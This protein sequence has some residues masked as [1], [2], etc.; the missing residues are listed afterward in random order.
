MIEKYPYFM[1]KD[2]DSN[3]Y[4]VTKVYDTPF[5][6]LYN[7]LYKVYQDFH[8]NK[9]IYIWKEQTAPYEYNIHFHTHHPL[10][11]KIT[12]YK[13]NIPINKISVPLE[14]YEE[15]NSSKIDLYDSNVV[16][17]VDENGKTIISPIQNWD[18]TY[19]CSYAKT[20]MH[21]INVYRCM[22][23]GSLYFDDV[24]PVT[25]TS[26]MDDGSV[27]GGYRYQKLKLYQCSA[28]NQI[29]YGV[30]L[31]EVVNTNNSR[32]NESN[33]Q[34][35]KCTGNFTE[36][37]AYRCLVCGQIWFNED[38]APEFCTCV[39][40][41][42]NPTPSY[43]PITPPLY[44]NDESVT[45][46]DNATD[47]TEDG[48]VY[49]RRL[50][51]NIITGMGIKLTNI[52]VELYNPNPTDDDIASMVE[53]TNNDG[54]VFFENVSNGNKYLKFI[55]N[56][57]NYNIP[58]SVSNN[59]V[60]A[61]LIL[62]DNN[63]NVYTLKLLDDT[64]VTPS[65]DSSYYESEFKLE[66]P[67]I[68]DDLFHMEVETW[69]EYLI[70]KGFPE[71]DMPLTDTNN[72]IIP[73]IYDHDY[74]LDNFGALNNIPRKSYIYV[75]DES[76]YPFTEPPFNNRGT[77]DDYH[78]MLRILEYV[79]RLYTTPPPCLELWKMYGLESTIVNREKYLLKVFDITKHNPITKQDPND[80]VECW[81]P[82]D[83]EHKD[84]FCDGK[85]LYGVYFYII[86]ET[87]RPYPYDDVKVELLLM[88]GL[89]ER[90]D[91][92]F[93]VKIEQIT[94]NGTIVREEEYV[95]DYYT[96]PYTFLSMDKPNPFRFTGYD[97]TGK[98]MPI[99]I[100]LNVRKCS[101]ADWFVN[102]GTVSTRNRYR[103]NYGKTEANPFQT[104]DE[105]LKKVT[106]NDTSICLKG[107]STTSVPY[108]V[109]NSCVIMGKDNPKI[110][111]SDE[112]KRVFDIIGGKDASLKLINLTLATSK[113]NAP[114]KSNVW[115]NNSSLISD[116]CY[117]IL[118]GGTVRVTITFDKTEYFLYDT[119]T[120]NIHLTKSDGKTVLPNNQLKVFYKDQELNGSPLT[121]NSNG[122]A[123]ITFTIRESELGLYP[124]KVQNISDIYFESEFVEDVPVTRV[125]HFIDNN[126]P[127]NVHVT[128]PSVTVVCMYINT[129]EG[130]PVTDLEVTHHRPDGFVECKNVDANGDA[131][132]DNPIT[133]PGKYLIVITDNNG[134]IIDEFVV[135][136]VYTISDFVSKLN[137]MNVNLIS[138]FKI[139]TTD[140]VNQTF[141]MGDIDYNTLSL[142]SSS[143]LKDF[144]GVL[145]SVSLDNSNENE[146]IIE[147][148]NVD[149]ER[150]DETNLKW[151][152]MKELQYA[153]KSVTFNNDTAILSVFSLGEFWN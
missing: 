86:P 69:D 116:N 152:D 128:D 99:Q 55:Y 65:L 29:Y 121:T 5:Q 126:T 43:T 64:Y 37:N 84:K 16:R 85:S 72:Q 146:I 42:N 6:Y 27:C 19:T 74:S 134:H 20:N 80:L 76:D 92:P 30:N 136:S 11:K 108:P 34:E 45:I 124:F 4:K 151:S 47:Y 39:D 33:Y 122:D 78:Y 115:N 58:L 51:V 137:S 110:T 21:K 117:V 131:T 46:I 53:K 83:W 31:D 36:V 61:D 89:A 114:I 94:D 82:T 50:N 150:E 140:D 145:L 81:T 32:Y 26:K 41:N 90:I 28:N 12:F 106:T 130:I 139:R 15:K 111:T 10:V 48:F 7:D 44:Y 73:S 105:A 119:V 133:V 143:T 13:N 67:I 129:I 66:I 70:S 88:N 63:T 38:D 132:F 101:E 127:I 138:D 2:E 9:K 3:N 49:G 23:C 75:E 59:T 22:S 144:D 135:E 79:Q 62:D 24:L 60:G 91:E 149:S 103:Y 95:G 1:K 104:L 35:F 8:I 118:N 17:T 57:H 52:D 93:Y 123:T 112:D 56:N 113:V 97:I 142:T 98:E 100:V 107:N 40:S 96:I 120:A 25:C 153:I 71:N 125:T 102:T 77:E 18:W 147:S 148:F 141:V 54:N 87:L 14:F 68:P 109:I